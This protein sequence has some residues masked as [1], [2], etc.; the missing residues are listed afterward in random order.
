MLPIKYVGEWCWVKT[1]KSVNET[2]TA[3]DS[4]WKY[5]TCKVGCGM[6][7]EMVRDRGR[8]MGETRRRNGG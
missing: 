7:R 5:L 2:G 8:G 6:R 4:D 3:D 1:E